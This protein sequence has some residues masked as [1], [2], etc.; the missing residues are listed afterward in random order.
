MATKIYKIIPFSILALS[1]IILTPGLAS[2]HQPR[3]VQ[4]ETTQVVDQEISKAYY[5]T[6]TGSPHI[7]TIDSKVDMANKNLTNVRRVKNAGFYTQYIS[8]MHLVKLLIN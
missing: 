8:I 7:Y 5:A 2:A 4:S 3:I 6:I 1:V